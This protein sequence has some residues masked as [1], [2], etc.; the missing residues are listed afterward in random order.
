MRSRTLLVALELPSLRPL[1]IETLLL[2]SPAEIDLV[3]KTAR[4]HPETY[5]CERCGFSVYL[6]NSIKKEPLWAHRAGA[7]RD[8]DWWTGDP[9]TK[10]Q[11]WKYSFK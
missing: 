9:R 6:Q 3:R 11:N 4:Q 8:C 7:P 1:S 5:A 2:A 10:K